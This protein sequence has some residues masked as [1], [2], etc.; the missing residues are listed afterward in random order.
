[1]DW[2]NRLPRPPGSH[3]TD[4]VLEILKMSPDAYRREMRA[5][6]FGDG[7][8]DRELAELARVRE[9]RLVPGPAQP[10]P[11]PPPP[12]DAGVFEFLLRRRKERRHTEDHDD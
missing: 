12:A 4:H 11:P 6:G 8:I 10:A 3:L 7:Y 2:R 5:A 1:M 9:Q